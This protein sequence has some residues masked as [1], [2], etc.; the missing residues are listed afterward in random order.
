MAPSALTSSRRVAS[1]LAI[2]SP[3]I[4][5]QTLPTTASLSLKGS[6]DGLRQSSSRTLSETS[7]SG[8]NSAQR[9]A[10]WK[11]TQ[12]SWSVPNEKIH[13]HLWQRQHAPDVHRP[14]DGH[15]QEHAPPASLLG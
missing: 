4:A 14:A 9:F 5:R 1:P 8:L 11:P 7:N 13:P 15:H 2:I 3:S 10:T 6:W 12:C